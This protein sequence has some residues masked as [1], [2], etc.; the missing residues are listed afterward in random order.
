MRRFVSA[1]LITFVAL[2][3]FSGG[4]YFFFPRDAALAF[5]WRKGV[6]AA[7]QKGVTLETAALGVEGYLPFRIVFRNVRVAAPVASMEAGAMTVSPR[8]VESLFSFAPT[9]EI[10]FESLSLNL[11]LPGQ[12]PLVFSSYSSIASLLS[13][14]VRLAEIRTAGDLQVAGEMTVNLHTLKL[15]EADISI[16]GERTALLEYVKT[17]LPLQREASGT[18]TLKR[19]GG[20]NK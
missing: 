1:L 2:V 11:P 8:F 7:S 9:A 15:D 17:M 13:S 19:K 10:N 20:E 3:S 6:L 5:F 18:W 16:S 4:L 14:G 12:P